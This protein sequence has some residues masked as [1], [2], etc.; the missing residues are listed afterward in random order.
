MRKTTAYYR[1]TVDNKESRRGNKRPQSRVHA[2]LY[3]T[4]IHQELRLEELNPHLLIR[5]EYLR[6]AAFDQEVEGFAKDVR[7]Y[8]VEFCVRGTVSVMG[9]ERTNGEDTLIPSEIPFRYLVKCEHASF[10]PSVIDLSIP[11]VNTFP[12]PPKACGHNYPFIDRI[13]PLLR[14]PPIHYRRRS[15]HTFPLHVAFCRHILQKLYRVALLESTYVS[16]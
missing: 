13:G 14:L 10:L 8:C 5:A 16:R 7:V 2:A 15:P 4:Y 6:E 12:S 11:I 9:G 3:Y 1:T